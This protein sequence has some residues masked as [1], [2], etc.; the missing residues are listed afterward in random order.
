[1][2]QLAVERLHELEERAHKYYDWLQVLSDVGI[3]D[4]QD[5][6]GQYLLKCPFHEDKRPSFR[7]RVKE[8]NYH[9]FSC[10]A[11]GSIADLMWR[12][13]GQSVSKAQYCEQLLKRT[14]ALQQELGF[15]SLYIDSSSLDKGFLSRRKFDPKNHIGGGLQISTLAS[16]IKAID[17]SWESLVYSLTMLQQGERPDIILDT[18]KKSHDF[19]SKLTAVDVGDISDDSTEGFA[20]NEKGE[21][22]LLSLFDDMEAE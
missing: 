18:V 13:S 14:P 7:I 10:N 5:L 3:S 11:F 4:V 2:G 17:N 8:H 21:V 16:S 19:K 12:L 22:S 9:C 1:M 6:Q 15:N 20:T